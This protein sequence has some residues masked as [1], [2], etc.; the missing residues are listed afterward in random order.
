MINLPVGDPDNNPFSQ[1][2]EQVML[3]ILAVHMCPLDCA[4][5]SRSSMQNLNA[6][7]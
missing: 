4:I 1:I 6:H 2:G 7:I 5:E 3:K